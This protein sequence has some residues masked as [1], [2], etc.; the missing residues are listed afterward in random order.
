MLN[1]EIKNLNGGNTKGERKMT[2]QKALSLSEEDFNKLSDECNGFND[3]VY[4][5]HRIHK[6]GETL[7]EFLEKGSKR[8]KDNPVIKG[9][10]I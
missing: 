2:V 4:K 6:D 7:G 8:I 5:N 10:L 1:S 3:E 9:N